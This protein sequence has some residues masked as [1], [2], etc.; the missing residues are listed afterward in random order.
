MI[1]VIQ[2]KMVR[3][4]YLVHTLGQMMQQNTP[5]YPQKENVKLCLENLK[6]LHPEI[7]VDKEW[8][9][10]RGNSSI[11]WPND[12]TTV[13]AFALFGPKQ[14]EDLLYPMINNNQFN[15]HW[16]GEHTDIYHACMDYR[17]FEF[18]R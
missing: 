11:Y 14:F 12:P 3:Q 18:S 17:C 8:L 5:P 15:I 2:I 1:R 4:S 9:D 13:G 10:G 16:A 7:D 6:I